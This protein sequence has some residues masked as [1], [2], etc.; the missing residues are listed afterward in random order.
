MSTSDT[1]QPA[2]AQ[3][4]HPDMKKCLEGKSQ[5][6]RLLPMKQDWSKETLP[7]SGCCE[8][9]KPPLAASH[10]GWSAQAGVCSGWGLRG[11]AGEQRTGGL[12]TKKT[13]LELSTPEAT[14][15]AKGR[16]RKS[17]N[18]KAQDNTE[19]LF[20][21]KTKT[22]KTPKNSWLSAWGCLL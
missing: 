19:K 4:Q 13:F 16:G 15:L 14:E 1:S 17:P 7:A 8:P 22:K 18:K 5:N 21:I 6:Q 11:R 2:A 9:E 12:R 20:F 10:S 3:S